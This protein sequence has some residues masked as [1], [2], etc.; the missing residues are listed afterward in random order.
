MPKLKNSTPFSTES[1]ILTF[2]ERLMKRFAAHE[3][4]R[5]INLDDEPFY[6]QYLPQ[7]SETFEFTP[8]PMKITYRD[9]P[10]SWMLNPGESE[11]IIGENAYVMIEALYKKL[12]A[13]GFLKKHGINEPGKPGRNFNWS[14]GNKQEELIDKIY[15]GKETPVFGDAANSTPITPR[16]KASTG[17]IRTS[18]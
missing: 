12:V 4:V 15:L 9:D 17:R 10:E 2:R 1:S 14:D 5:V 8:D 7:H 16:V 18:S 3:W 13:K 11:V 6:W